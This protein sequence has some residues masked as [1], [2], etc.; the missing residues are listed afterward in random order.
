MIIQKKECIHENTKNSNFP[1]ELYFSTLFNI[2][3]YIL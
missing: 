1:G 3:N 2:N